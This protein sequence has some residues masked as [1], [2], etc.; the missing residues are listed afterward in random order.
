M[1][2]KDYYKI[3]GVSRK[4]SKDEIRKAYRNLAVQ[5]HPDKNMG[6]K[7][8]EE[9]FK[10]I[11]EAYQ[12]LNDTKKRSHYDRLG[13]A[14][15]NWQQQGQ[16]GFDWDQWSRGPS[17]G[18]RRA[19][20]DDFDG[21]FGDGIFSDFFSS[22]FGGT[23][24]PSRR[25]QAYQQQVE[26]SMEDAHNGVSM[27]IET[28]GIRKLVKIPP[29][30]RTGSKVRVA[31]AGPNGLDLYLIIQVRE[32]K[33]FK[34]KGNNLHIATKISAY[35]AILGGEV[36]INTLTGKVKLT[37][38]PGTQPDQVFRIAGRGMPNL[39]NPKTKGNL[40]VRVSVEIPRSLSS[41]QRELL[42]KASKI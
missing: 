19:N 31:G 34:R 17:R 26:I 18:T 39:K 11:N 16:G 14:Y 40:Y 24:A 42:E 25:N 32:H 2:Y 13:S 29:G 12:V 20:V 21:I 6:D 27:R 23:G 33:R 7:Q 37:I 4:A 38:P 8:A 28:E 9:R 41:K 10:D 15:S 5:Y 22:I 1:D 30:V 3:L 36:E 35:T